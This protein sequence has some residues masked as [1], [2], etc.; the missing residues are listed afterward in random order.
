VFFRDQKGFTL[1]LQKILAQKLGELTGKP[2][3]SGLHIHP[4]NNA[5]RGGPTDERGRVNTDDEVSVIS[6]EQ[7]KLFNNN[8]YKKTF[9]SEGWHSEY[10]YLDGTL[11]LVSH[12]SQFQ[13]TT[14]Y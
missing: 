8:I 11:T 2:A 1:A 13:P 4:V 6:S 10:I 9:A 12:L 7:G 14:R 3:S 5:G